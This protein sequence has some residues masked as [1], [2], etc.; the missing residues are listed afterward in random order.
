MHIIT[1][2]IIAAIC[3]GTIIAASI[4]PYDKAKVYLHL[5]FMDDS[6]I[7]PANKNTGMTIR[8]N[9]I[10][11]GYSGETSD[12]GEVV[13]PKYAELYAEI[14]SKALGITV[15]V[16]WGSDVELF[17][18][19]ACQ[20]TSSAVIGDKGNTVISAHV[21]TYFS[22]LGGLDVGDTVTLNTNYGEFTYTVREKIEFKSK[23]KSYIVPKKE[24]LLT[25]Y[26]CKKDVFGSS[27]KRFGVVCELTERKFYVGEGAEN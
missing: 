24:D 1:P 16:Y 22:D 26:T 23:D 18:R 12:E 10:I 9:K 4:K 20:A 5:A 7:D 11:S 14:T 25:L 2:I 3:L 21:D 13:R 6:K 19:G 8:D 15:P 17:E 27:D